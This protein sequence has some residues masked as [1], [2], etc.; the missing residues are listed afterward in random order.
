M[1]LPK[2]K[3][4]TGFNSNGD[5]SFKSN[6]EKPYFGPY[7]KTYEGK[8]YAGD[9]P[10]YANL[11]ELVKNT[12]PLADGRP[13]NPLQ[14]IDTR[15]EGKNNYFYSKQSGLDLRTSPIPQPPICKKYVPTQQD[16]I[17]GSYMRYFAKK[18]NEFSYVEIDNPT[19]I[20][21]KNQDPDTLWS[22]YSCLA[23]KW[24]T[25]DIINLQEALKIEK[26]H[27]WLGFSVYLKLKQT[28]EDNSTEEIFRSSTN[29]NTSTPSY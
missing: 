12:L 16:F 27:Q 29:I 23:M 19:Y 5:L 25:N 4:K 22:L 14:G 7:F 8:M 3:I 17:N 20:K 2:N 21:F 10:N 24:K 1:Y 28:P 26:K 15:F 13:P 9:N 6:P 18:S 11:V